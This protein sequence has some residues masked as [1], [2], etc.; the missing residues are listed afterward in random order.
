M[1]NENKVIGTLKDAKGRPLLILMRTKRGTLMHVFKRYKDM[2]S[3]ER[4]TLMAM[5][6]NLAS[7]LGGA[8]V[9]VQSEK[10]MADFLDFKDDRPCG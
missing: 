10:E 7:G 5:Y 2:G 9:G 1:A 8:I 3:K 6:G 4:G